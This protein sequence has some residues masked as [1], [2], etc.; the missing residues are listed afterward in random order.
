MLK[1][2]LPIFATLILAAFAS[3]DN[4]TID[5]LEARAGITGHKHPQNIPGDRLNTTRCYYASNEWRDDN[6]FGH[7]YHFDYYNVHLDQNFALDAVCNSANTVSQG[8]IKRPLCLTDTYN[9][10]HRQKFPD[11][12]TLCY[13]VN[14]GAWDTIRFKKKK[15]GVAI[16]PDE[17]LADDTVE[18]L[19]TKM[20]REKVDVLEFLRGEAWRKQVAKT[21]LTRWPGNRWSHMGVYWDMDDMCKTCA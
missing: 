13:E 17:L 14:G 3:S 18:D 4:V 2:A 6:R 8:G 7:Y 1:S 9:E 16:V 19:Y 20:C 12:N 15:R 10:K 11:G 5:L 21:F